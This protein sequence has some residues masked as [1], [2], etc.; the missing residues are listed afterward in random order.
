MVIGRVIRYGSRVISKKVD[1]ALVRLRDTRERLGRVGKPDNPDDIKIG[2]QTAARAG[3]IA[4]VMFLI[5]R[6]ST[7][8][9]T[10][11]IQDSVGSLLFLVYLFEDSFKHEAR[12]LDDLVD[13]LLYLDARS[14][15]REVEQAYQKHVGAGEI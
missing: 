14:Y 7:R 13:G 8:S 4:Q 9:P 11:F 1:A 10:E 6:A 3:D 2:I 15:V 5:S 12:D